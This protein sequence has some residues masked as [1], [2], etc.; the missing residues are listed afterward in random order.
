LNQQGKK[1][2][3]RQYSQ[4]Q[5]VHGG[6]GYVDAEKILLAE[7]YEPISLPHQDQFSLKAKIN[8]LLYTVRMVFTIK[9]DSVVV[10]LF[11]VYA[12][13]N[14]LLLRLLSAKGVKLVCFITDIN[15][16]KDGDSKRLKKDIRFFRRFRYFIVHNEKMKQWL[17]GIV[18][19][20]HSASIEFFDFLA[21]N[22]TVINTFSHN[23]IFAGNLGK[24]TFLEKLYL[25]K[26]KCPS[27]QFNLYG[28]GQTEAMTSQ[29]NV[30]WRGV[31]NPYE[32][33][34][35]LKGGFGLLWD[36]DSIDKPGGSLGHYMQYISHHKLSLYIISRLPVIVPAIA[37]SAALVD[38]YR[39]GFSVNSLYELEERL[40]SISIPEYQQMQNNMSR[41]AQKISRGGC[42]REALAEIMEM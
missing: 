28:Q 10:F 37:A 24:S 23:I 29:D 40:K 7:G 38:K 36:G 33:P 6:I 39:I 35:K 42:L 27:V 30:N 16:L 12:M 18:P 13:M 14:R 20:N 19:G 1:Y 11:P 41:L 34:L 26:E 8:R 2:F 31:E 22:L 5:Y 15:G 32:L 17:D 25:L 3:I 4:E 21:H 9:K